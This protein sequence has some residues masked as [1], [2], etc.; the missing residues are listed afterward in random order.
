M[1][2]EDIV[3]PYISERI[4]RRF[5][6]E[7]DDVSGPWA[8]LKRTTEAIRSAKGFPP[9]HPINVRTSMMENFLTT[10][11]GTVRSS[12]VDASLTHPDASKDPLMDQ[13]IR[14]AQGGKSY[15]R[16][17]PRPVIGLNEFDNLMIQSSLIRY[18]FS[19]L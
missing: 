2:L 14:A 18:M 12:T 11:R 4:A 19:G 9:A 8:P 5:Y 17:V 3:E 6:G 15:P 10:N 16:T 13:K 1:F 7:G